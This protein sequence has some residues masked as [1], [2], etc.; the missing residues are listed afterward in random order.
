MFDGSV[1]HIV[2]CGRK[3]DAADAWQ[4]DIRGNRSNFGVVRE[5][6]NDLRSSSRNR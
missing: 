2:L 6:L 5:E 1:V 4:V 3:Q